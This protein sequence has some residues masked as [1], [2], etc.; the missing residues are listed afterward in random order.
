[1]SPCENCCSTCCS[2]TPLPIWVLLTPCGETANNSAKSEFEDLKPVV[3]ELAMLFAVTFR[4]LCA[5]SRPLSAIPKDMSSAPCEKSVDLLD[6]TE[7]NRAQ[8]RRV[9]SG[10]GTS[11]AERHARDRAIEQRGGRLGGTAD[12]GGRRHAIGPAGC[13]LAIAGSAVP[14]ESLQTGSGRHVHLIDHGTGGVVDREHHAGGAGR[15]LHR[16]AQ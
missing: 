7:R 3:A 5:A 9:E 14:A 10:A 11:G 13:G 12:F 6:R 15:H 4:L 2:C 8:L 1:M 16:A